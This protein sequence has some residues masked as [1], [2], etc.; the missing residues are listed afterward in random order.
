MIQLVRVDHRLIHGQVSFA[1]T[2]Q[3]EADCIL[4]ASDDLVKDELKMSVMR[5]AKP[6]DVKLVMK[7]I[8]DSALSL[9][10]G[11]TDKYRLL[12]LCE[13]IKDVY[14]L[15]KK[16]NCIHEVNLGG[17][18]SDPHRK[19]I[20]KA[21]HVSEEDVSMIRELNEQGIQLNVQLVPNDVKQ[22][23]MKLL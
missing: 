18:K 2:K 3:V 1:W 11:Q 19:Q 8:D 17:T 10:L 21:V 20:S 13:S 15:I 12:V 4:I 7:N 9:N 22:N 23:V 6:S 5:M 16:T 14:S